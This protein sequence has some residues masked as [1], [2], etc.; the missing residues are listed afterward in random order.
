MNQEAIKKRIA[1][2]EEE[3][4]YHKLQGCGYSIVNYLLPELQKHK[5]MLN[6]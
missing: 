6:G 2:L 3:I 1:S 5:A 4:E